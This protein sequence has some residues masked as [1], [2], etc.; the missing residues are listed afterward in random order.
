MLTLRS[1]LAQ[2][3]VV[4]SP[5]M[6]AA[7]R[8]R[9]WLFI[10]LLAVVVA[11]VLFGVDYYRHRFVRSDA[12]MLR[13]LPGGDATRFFA[14]VAALRRVGVL[15][16]FTG[17][18]TAEDKDYQDFVRQTH[19]DYTKDVDAIAGAAD[20]KQ[21]FFIVR[22][23]LDWSRL[24][25]YALSH[26]GACERK[27]CRIP[28]SKAGQWASFVP[29]Q[30]DVIG[31]AVSTNQS[32]AE[33]LEPPGRLR[34]DHTPGDPVWVKPSQTLLKEPLA[35]PLPLRIFAISLESVG[36]VVVSLAPATGNSG[37]AFNVKLTAECPSEATAEVI[38]NQ[39]EIQ[40]K[41]LK[42]ELARERAQPNP[43]DLTGLLTAGTFQVVDKR[44]IGIWPV[45]KELLKALQ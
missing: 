26:G 40:T 25:Q 12:D 15:G 38:R 19:F 7:I 20:G 37:A 28:T 29:I 30:P 4:S 24:R 11:A 31:L 3:R 10:T 5:T 9:P 35:L 21:L 42:L 34:S 43:G 8:L 22:G 44:V 27:F 1:A 36:P 33:T 14:D 17:T 16:M 23:H 18:K 41:M 6:R 13:L 32:A 2:G 39:L 45:R